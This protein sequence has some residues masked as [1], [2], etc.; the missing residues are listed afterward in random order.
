MK[1]IK[2]SIELYRKL[3]NKYPNKIVVS[4]DYYYKLAIQLNK[5]E[6]ECFPHMR[7]FLF[8]IELAIDK[9]L[10]YDYKFVPEKYI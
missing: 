8:G 2:K 1:D 7:R 6:M 5:G 10:Q 4:I 9:K 3:S